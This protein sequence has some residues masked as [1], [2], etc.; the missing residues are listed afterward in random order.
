MNSSPGF[1]LLLYCLK[2][3]IGCDIDIMTGLPDKKNID[4]IDWEKW[5]N[6]VIGHGVLSQ[7]YIDIKNKGTAIDFFPV[8]MM[9][10]LKGLFYLNTSKNIRLCSELN[11][12]VK[13][14]Q[15]L[16]IGVIAFKGPVLAVQAYNDYTFRSYLDLDVLI[17]EHDFNRF[18]DN[19]KSLGYKPFC[20]FNEKM[21]EKWARLG[22]EYLFLK[23]NIYIDVHFRIQRGPKFTG[24]ENL[25]DPGKYA[26]VEIIDQPVRALSLEYSVLAICINGTKDGWNKLSFIVD[27]ASLVRN[28][29]ELKWDFIISQSRS[30]RVYSMLCTG[31]RLANELLGLPLPPGITGDDIGNKK[32]DRLVRVYKKILATG[33]GKDLPGNWAQRLELKAIDTGWAKSRYFCYYLFV[34]KISDL[35]DISVFGINFPFTVYLVLRP[36]LLVIRMLRGFFLSRVRGK[37]KRKGLIGN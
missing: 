36:F 22:R 6:L 27:L 2:L 18:Y 16:R 25:L 12:L 10:E 15:T 1:E 35:E 4:N 24:S 13:S 7:V 23:K 21:R 32:I 20:P 26:A 5:K 29:R 14:M 34:P 3:G 37:R 28:H 11:I 17:D 8:K 30:M 9:E 31:L 19:M 33:E